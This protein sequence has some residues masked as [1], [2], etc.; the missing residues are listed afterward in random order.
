MAT[1]PKLPDYPD[2]AP[3][4]SANPHGR[5]HLIRHGKFPWPIVALIVGATLLIAIIAVLPRGPRVRRPPLAEQ[6]PSRIASRKS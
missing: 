1:N 4:R 6:V 3:R 2:T 5:V